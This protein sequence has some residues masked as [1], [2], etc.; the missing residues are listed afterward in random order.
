MQLQNQAVIKMTVSSQHSIFFFTI[1]ILV[2]YD[3]SLNY[4]V[5]LHKNFT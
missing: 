4:S 2:T 3:S 1:L 5:Y